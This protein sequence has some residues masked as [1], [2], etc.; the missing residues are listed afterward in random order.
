MMPISMPLQMQST[1]T[2]TVNPALLGTLAPRLDADTFL[3]P[4]LS[5]V[6]LGVSLSLSLKFGRG[7]CIVFVLYIAS[8]GIWLPRW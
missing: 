3:A 4:K 1:T 2:A 5:S 6:G 8:K 7:L